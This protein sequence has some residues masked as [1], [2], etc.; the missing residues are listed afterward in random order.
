MPLTDSA[1]R[2][3]KPEAAI[4]KLSDA[5]GLHLAVNP[6]GSKLWRMNYRFDGKQKTLSFGPYPRVTLADA[7]ALRENAKR[8]LVDGIDP[9][10][11]KGK[12]ATG[13]HDSFEAIAREWHKGQ[14]SSWVPAHAERVLSRFDRDVFP[15]LGDR[16]IESITAP[17]ILEVLRAV[18]ARGAL[19]VTKRLRQSMGAVF[20]YAIATSR[21]ARDPVADLRGALKPNPKP[22]HMASLKANEIA[23]FIGKLRAYDG[24]R[25]TA[26]AVEF[27]LHTALRTNELRFGRWTEMDGDLWRIPAERMKA[28]R[29]HIVPLTKQTKRLLG[30]LKTIA[31]DSEWIVPGGRTG[32]PISQNTMIFALYR[33]GFHSKLTIHGLRGTFSTIANESGLWTPDSIER[34]LAHVPG[35]KVR[36]S[37]NHATY[38]DERR[39]LMTWWSD[40]LT[41]KDPNDLSALLA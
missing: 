31:G 1:C 2:A 9:A 36:S 6:N 35:N 24:E 8:A 37:Y 19:D 33:L 25:Q 21:A 29:D 40:Y 17:E 34:A 28:G 5:G 14:E 7:R 10:A 4:K 12:S 27:I 30:Q 32:K 13:A 15:T 16:R 23:N 26:L 39:R 11:I 20:R 18:E 41:A 3:A 22:V 38:L